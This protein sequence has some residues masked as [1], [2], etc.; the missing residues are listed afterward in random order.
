[1]DNKYSGIQPKTFKE[2]WENYWYH[3]K[4]RTIV[5]IFVA[6]AAILL[7]KD[8]FFKPKYD[9]ELT[10]V[11]RGYSDIGDYSKNIKSDYTKL[12]ELILEYVE[13]YNGDGK[14]TVNIELMEIPPEDQIKNRDLNYAYLTKFEFQLFL[15]EQ[16]LYIISPEIIEDMINKIG[17]DAE[18]LFLDLD[19]KYP[20]RAGEEGTLIDGKMYGKGMCIK[21]LLE[22]A[23]IK[24]LDGDGFL[25]IRDGEKMNGYKEERY[26]NEVAFFEK[27]MNSLV[28]A[29]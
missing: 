28:N 12:E 1:M 29:D 10:Y 5:G 19:E 13:D 17:T 14:K 27:I 25:M 7:I 20:D 4:F 6:V 21:G 16:S 9:I 2:K 15:G 3:Y 23:G 8:I 22:G 26:Q 18:T 24:V 11:V